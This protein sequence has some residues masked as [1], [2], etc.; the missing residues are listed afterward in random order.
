MCERAAFLFRDSMAD[1]LVM[2]SRDGE[3]CR[4]LSPMVPRGSSIF[5]CD[6]GKYAFAGDQRH[7]VVADD[8]C[9]PFK[10]SS[11]DFIVS[12][13]SLHNVNNQ[14]SVLSNIYAMLRKGGVLLAATF[15]SETLRGIKKAVILSERGKIVPRIQPFVYAYEVPFMLQYCGFANVVV[16]VS[17]V[18]VNYKSLYHLF[19]ELKDTGEGC[20]FRRGYVPSLRG[21]IDDAWNMYKKSIKKGGENDGVPVKYEIIIMKGEKR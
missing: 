6:V 12:N 20:T 16:D 17:I 5:Q 11:F 8:E 13:L 3:V 1:I 15:G 4:R 2:G 9:M 10:G 18:E 14:I 7:F 21:V 19:R